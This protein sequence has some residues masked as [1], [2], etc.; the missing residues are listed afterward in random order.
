MRIQN[1]AVSR[2][3]ELAEIFNMINAPL[4][5]PSSFADGKTMIYLKGKYI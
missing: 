4:E 5:K 2:H 1:A 3:F